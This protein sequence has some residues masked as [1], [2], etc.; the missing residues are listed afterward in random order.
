M[1]EIK[2]I[3]WASD[4]SDES[5]QALNYAIFLARRLGS[6][7]TGVN[8]IEM[9]PRLLYDYARD[10]DSE[11]YSWVEQSAENQRERLISEAEISGVQGIVFHLKV[12]IGDPTEEIVRLARR[13]KADLV[14]VGVRGMGLIDRM[15]VGSTTLKVLRKSG[16]P[17]LSVGKKD[18][19]DTI[20]IRNI[21]VP[22][23]VHE[24]DDSA[25]NYAVDLAEALKANVSVVYAYRL[26]AYTADEQ[27]K[28]RAGM[29]KL[30]DDALKFFSSELAA[31]IEGP[32][33][34]LKAACGLD[35][36]GDLIEG[37]NPALSIVEYAKNKNADLIVINTHARKGIK[38]IMMGSVTEKVV[39]ESHCPVLALKP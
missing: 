6:E 25:L 18:G 7:I 1:R 38:K 37:R 16:T 11:L 30:G 4:G 2:K 21:L 39:Q 26:F 32:R 20:G 3:I 28:A 33:Q 31:R 35:I 8:V 19:G 23:D 29:N 14:V 15:L 24:K 36:T 13:K 9:H 22:L 34:R 12:L 17:I 27:E 10:P 5:M